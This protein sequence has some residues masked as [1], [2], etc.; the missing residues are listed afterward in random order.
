MLPVLIPPGATISSRMTAAV[1][2]YS[3]KDKRNL[4]GYAF[5]LILLAAGITFIGFRSYYLFE[6]QYRHEVNNQL[7][8]IAELKMNGLENWRTERL[9]DTNFIYKNEAFSGLLARYLISPQDSTT[10]RRIAGWLEKFLAYDEYDQV[11]LLDVHG[12]TLIS[13]GIASPVSQAVIQNLPEVEASGQITFVDLYSDEQDHLI[14][15]SLLVPIFESAQSQRVIALLAL[16]ID[17]RKYLYPFIREWPSDS[18]TA[19]T[20]LVRRE[21]ETALFLNDVR[22]RPDTALKFSIPLSDTRK[23]AVKAVLDQTGTV[24]GLDYRGEPVIGDV[25][26]VPGSPWFLVTRMDI[27]EV[28]LPLRER[29]WQTFGL[30]A[31]ILISASLAIVVI[32]RQQRLRFY[33]TQAET[34]EALRESLAEKETLLKE[35]HHRVKNNLA[36]INALIN[37]QR[38]HSTDPTIAE[39]FTDLGGRIQSM[40]LVH[41]LLYQ[42]RTLSHVRMQ[43]YLETLAGHLSDSY[44]SAADVE[45]IIDAQ[46]VEMDLDHAIPCGLIVNE[47]VTNAFKYAFPAGRLHQDD[48]YEIR[49]TIAR[50]GSAYTLTVCDNGVGLPADVDWTKTKSLGMQLVTMLGQRQLNGEVSL[51]RTGGTRFSLRFTPKTV[52]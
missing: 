2:H 19:E 14:H 22:F 21:D 38:S 50:D 43:E 25:R 6:Q 11:S 27:A 5:I 51:D 46:D 1:D 44:R 39:E 24:E 30:V 41:E 29:L 52:R 34:A 23:L 7:S 8:A 9:N 4:L 49:V 40:A 45:V 13:M 17:P 28:Y 15:L 26:A 18:A 35:V 42:S 3:R 37:L 12:K 32:W 48:R 36:S 31:A 33:R 16:Q 20:L 47:L 10:Q